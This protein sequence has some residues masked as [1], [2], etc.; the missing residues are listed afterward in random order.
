MRFEQLT[1]TSTGL[2]IGFLR[3]LLHSVLRFLSLVFLGLSCHA[4][5]E[6]PQ[7]PRG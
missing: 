4:V 7:G 2:F 5:Q 3:G 6:P 1:S